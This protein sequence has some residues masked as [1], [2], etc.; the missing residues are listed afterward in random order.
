[1]RRGLSGLAGRLA[2]WAAN[3][4]SVICALVG[5]LVVSIAA[6][7]LGRRA[8][9]LLFQMQGRDPVVFTVSV[10]L[11]A[12]I[13]G[14]HVNETSSI[15]AAIRRVLGKRWQLKVSDAPGGA[16]AMADY[17]GL[18]LR[19]LDAGSCNGC[20]L[21]IHMLNKKLAP[22]T[23]RFIAKRESPGMQCASSQ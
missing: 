4:V 11:L 19:H 9:S 21:E 5:V 12:V 8:E 20:E 13:A 18:K 10:G 16:M 23:T 2:R 17:M 14:I 7:V 6:V 1:M 3:I 15:E 22:A